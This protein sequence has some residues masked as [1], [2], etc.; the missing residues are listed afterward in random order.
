MS[1]E[2]FFIA[3]TSALG[4]AANSLLGHAA[5]KTKQSTAVD[6]ALMSLIP[7]FVM[8]LIIGIPL[9]NEMSALVLGLMI[10]KNSL[11]GIGF[12]LRYKGLSQIGAFQGSFLAGVQ[13]VLVSILS[14]LLLREN[15]ELRQW[16]ALALV[17]GA[18]LVPIWKEK[19]SRTNILN[20]A[21]LPAL[22]FSVVIVFDRWILLN[23][24]CPYNFF[25]L[26]KIILLPV[27]WLT[28]GLGKNFGQVKLH[29]EKSSS[30]F[31]LL[32]LGLTWGVAS[33]TYGVSLS[34]EK[35]AMVV[36]FRNLA[37]PISALLSV[38]FFAEPLTRSR[39]FSI[40]LIISACAIGL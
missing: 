40:F 27:V 28:L 35:T 11:Y 12:Y 30:Y 39:A 37:F 29:L 4:N 26:D 14:L 13:P 32:T 2:I 18:L 25:A 33:Y 22:L 38:V 19:L 9:I 16:L 7:S 17:A 23:K 3:L 5:L 6:V 8:A 20:F 10:V 36:L 34:G 15:L 1:I 24:L 21:L 31:W